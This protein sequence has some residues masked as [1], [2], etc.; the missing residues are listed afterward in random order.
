MLRPI[1]LVLP[2]D[3]HALPIVLSATESITEIL[4]FEKKE[5][6]KLQIGVE[7]AAANVINHA[8]APEENAEYEIIFEPIPLGIKVIIKETGI[9]F[10]PSLIPDYQKDK[11]FS[12]ETGGGLGYYMMRQ[13][14]DEVSFH[15]LG[16]KGKETHLLKY[17]S[18]KTVED[19]IGKT[20]KEDAIKEKEEKPLEQDISYII[21]PMRISEAVEVSKGAYSSYGYSY[22]YEHI[23]FPE[24]VR[25][26]LKT[27]KLISYVAV[28]DSGEIISHAAL[29]VDDMKDTV[30]LGLAFTKPKYR[31][32]GCL[33]KLNIALL[34]YA[35]KHNIKGIVANAVTT[36][37]YSQK[38]LLRANF[39]DCAISLSR[40]HEVSFKG[41][42]DKEKQRETTAIQFLYLFPPEKKELYI[43]EY[44]KQMVEKIYNSLGIKAVFPKYNNAQ[45]PVGD[46]AL[47]IETD[48]Y[49]KLATIYIRKYGK[50]STSRIKNTLK[51]LCIDRF[52]TII[53]SLDIE[54]QLT[55]PLVPEF[56]NLG[57]FFCGIMPGLKGPDQLLLQFLNNQ[58]INY[59]NIVMVS[60]IG[61]EMLNYIREKDKDHN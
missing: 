57:F 30:E 55:C 37:P 28:T 45:S 48:P 22:M 56:E 17:S 6:K 3:S 31:G 38:A 39:K 21:R 10:D 14:V 29:K 51:D 32:K 52:E 36:H 34:N 26:L 1:R 25:E 12:E 41:M 13:T 50:D 18:S 58:I 7:E 33:N 2:N 23:Y 35:T 61:K 40:R 20:E 8:F 24:R 11:A 59:D 53:L 4:G 42:N 43:P 5:I 49:H 60:E 27:E 47:D 46:T 54:D 19:F 9:P 16:A 15:N 44:H